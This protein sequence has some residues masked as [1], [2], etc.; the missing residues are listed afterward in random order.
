MKEYDRIVKSKNKVTLTRREC[1]LMYY[2]LSRMLDGIDGKLTS[3]IFFEFD[4]LRSKIP[5]P[6]TYGGKI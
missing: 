2:S 5:I 3:E 1:E 4:N 6:N